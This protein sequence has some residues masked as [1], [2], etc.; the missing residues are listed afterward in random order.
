MTI[1]ERPAA[2]QPVRRRRHRSPVTWARRGGISN[3][4]FLLP[5]LVIFGLFSWFPIVRALVMS[6]QQTNLVSPAHWVGLDNFSTVFNDPELPTALRNTGYFALLALVFG[7]PLPLILA[8]LMSEV[9][10]WRGV[11]TA[12]AYIP[13]VVP[14]VVSVLLWKFFYD[15]SSTGVF[16]TVAGWVGLGPYPWLQSASSA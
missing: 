5:L 7:Y 3:I 12:L 16:N 1:L 8:V 10:R 13:V 11:F 4:V 6:L 15:A 2:V 14:P 9:R